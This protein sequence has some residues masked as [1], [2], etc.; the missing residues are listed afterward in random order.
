MDTSQHTLHTL[1]DQLG[2]PSGQGAIDSFL[3]NHTLDRDTRLDQADFWS[4]GQAQFIREALE[5]DSD[6]SEIV[7]QLDTLLRG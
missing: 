6:W 1:F 7:D 2:L 3:E 5:E 4:A